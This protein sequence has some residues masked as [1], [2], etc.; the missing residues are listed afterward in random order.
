MIPAR[1]ELT[2]TLK[3]KI[4]KGLSS[5]NFETQRVLEDPNATPEQIEDAEFDIDDIRQLNGREAGANRQ[6]LKGD[7]RISE[8]IAQVVDGPEFNFDVRLGDLLNALD[9]IVISDSKQKGVF[10]KK[11][12][13]FA[14]LIQQL[15]DDGVAWQ[16]VQLFNQEEARRR[17][18]AEDRLSLSDE[19]NPGDQYRGILRGVMT[20][21]AT[22]DQLE[23]IIND[24]ALRI[25]ERVRKERL[26]S[27]SYIPLLVIGAGIHGS[28]F[29]SQLLRTDPDLAKS[30]VVIEPSKILGGQFRAVGGVGFDI[31]SRTR[32]HNFFEPDKNLPGETGNINSMGDEAMLQLPD[33]VHS[34]YGNNEDL[35]LIAAVNSFLSA[36]TALGVELVKVRQNPE[37]R[38][39]RSVGRY[40]AE[41]RDVDTNERILIETDCVFSSTGLGEPYLPFDE[42]DVETQKILSERK[43]KPLVSASGE[44]PALPSVATSAEFW[45]YA[46]NNRNWQPITELAGKDIV[47]VGDADSTQTIIEKLHG[48]LGEPTLD[49]QTSL[50]IA[51]NNADKPITV[52]IIGAK[53]E[54]YEEYIKGRR[55]R[56]HFVALF[57][58]REDGTRNNDT[59]T[60]IKGKATRLKREA[61]SN[62]VC[63]RD[64]FGNEQSVR[65][66]LI[67]TG[68]GFRDTS[69]EIF[70]EFQDSFAGRTVENPQREVVREA[71]SRVGSVFKV[72]VNG[73]PI[74]LTISQTNF[75]TGLSFFGRDVS[76]SISTALG[77][78]T[79]R[80]ISAQQFLLNYEDSAESVTF[81]SSTPETFVV[82][83]DGNRPIGRQI[84]SNEGPQDIFIGGV[85]GKD[86]N[87]SD[88]EKASYP[89]ATQD[90]VKILV[91]TDAIWRTQGGTVAMAKT[92]IPDSLANKNWESKVAEQAERSMVAPERLGV[93]DGERPR[94]FVLNLDK[95]EDDGLL[96][97][98]I[99]ALDHLKEALS[100]RLA[101]WRLD[102]GV[103]KKLKDEFGGDIT[104]RFLRTYQDTYVLTI[105]PPL[106]P[107][108]VLKE[109]FSDLSQ[110]QVRDIR[111]DIRALL[112]SRGSQDG[113]Q[114]SYPRNDLDNNAVQRV[115]SYRPTLSL[116]LKYDG[117]N[118]KPSSVER[119]KVDIMENAPEGEKLEILVTPS[120]DGSTQIESD[121]FGKR[122]VRQSLDAHVRS[123]LAGTSRAQSKEKSVNVREELGLKEGGK[124]TGLQARELFKAGQLQF[125]DFYGLIESRVKANKGEEAVI[126][127][128]EL[129]KVPFTLRLDVAK[130][131]KLQALV[132]AK[133]LK[134]GPSQSEFFQWRKVVEEIEK[135]L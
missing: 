74:T 116:T 98:N 46:G 24:E 34:V 106:F 17:Q 103:S 91:N 97:L 86:Y 66:D 12:R 71:L 102:S 80:T 48:I 107:V 113:I 61:G 55:V 19:V 43:S 132:S 111:R 15:K 49:T 87:F 4:L 133:Y 88:A 37:Y 29:T 57:Y 129:F 73:I 81:I 11:L 3:T 100:R 99:N 72:R 23:L 69:K 41:L 83:R 76:Y 5:D 45:K 134:Y 52:T 22:R 13:S 31:N 50:S 118:Y 38:S 62:A 117:K 10:A 2:N 20:N 40:I 114:V 96:P 16:K 21:E 120:S 78:E 82:L 84:I 127:F 104:L 35:G 77:V 1:S 123:V 25:S 47:I 63:Y 36:D 130:L 68:T 135:L 109:L 30:A 125:D 70:S 121:L 60:P 90:A 101:K 6:T 39:N 44:V 8:L 14:P 131:Q 42:S 27:G 28:I 115:I 95:S 79:S 59:I 110:T 58:P 85:Q 18:T 124:V 122:S 7:R 33:A 119:G 51:S 9:A 93:P 53:Q 105:D 89:D 94:Y 65:A 128:V 67:I 56:Y 126:D 112:G 92:I 26:R 108:S 64:E 54:S 75:K 32:P